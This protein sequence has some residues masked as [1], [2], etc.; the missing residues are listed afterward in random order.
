M[1]E[2]DIIDWQSLSLSNYYLF[3]RMKEGLRGK[4]YA[5]D[6][7]EE[8]AVMKWIKNSQQN[9]TSQEFKLSFEGRT[10][11]LWETMTMLRS[12]DMIHKRPASFSFR[13]MI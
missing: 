2:E 10:L 4:H 5:N 9:W 1:Q 12:R 13:C 3:H 11:Q 6:E 7:E 8:T